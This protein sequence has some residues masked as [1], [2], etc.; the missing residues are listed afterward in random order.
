[1]RWLR[2]GLMAVAV[3]C[4]SGCGDDTEQLDAETTIDSPSSPV[5]SPPLAAEAEQTAL[6]QEDPFLVFGLDGQT[7]ADTTIVEVPVWLVNGSDDDLV[8]AASAG[9][10]VVVLDT[11]RGRD[12]VIVY[13]QTR[14]DSVRLSATSG[15]GVSSGPLA[16]PTRL[17]PQRAAFHR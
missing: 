1:M 3:L 15:G 11:V 12:S 2:G 4:A 5:L 7:V 10:G 6:P 14:A 16:L 8:V 13:V 17:G 9:A